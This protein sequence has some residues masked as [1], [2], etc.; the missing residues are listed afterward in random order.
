MPKN[1]KLVALLALPLLAMGLGGLASPSSAQAVPVA[2]QVTVTPPPIGPR[3]AASE[4]EPALAIPNAAAG[5]SFRSGVA[6]KG[7]MAPP[8]TKLQPPGEQKASTRSLTSCVGSGDGAC[9]R[10]AGVIQTL[11]N[12]TPGLT[13]DGITWNQLIKDP[14]VCYPGV[15]GCQQSPDGGGF[16]LG[17][18][19]AYNHG[20]SGDNNAVELGVQ[21]YTN[22]GGSGVAVIRPFT[23]AWIDGDPQCYNGCGYL[24]NAA[25]PFNVGDPIPA[26]DYNTAQGFT[27]ERNI[28]ANPA[29]WYISYKG[30]Y[31]GYW[32]DA[33]FTSPKTTAM[34]GACD[35][36]VICVPQTFTTLALA[37]VYGEV[38]SGYAENCDDMG[39]GVLPVSSTSA[40]LSSITWIKS[41]GNFTYDAQSFFHTIPTAWDLQYFISSGSTTYNGLRYGGPGHNSLGE[42]PTMHPGATGACGGLVEG[43][44]AASELQVWKESC[45]DSDAVKGCDSAWH[46]PWSG[47]VI[48]AC[49]AV[50]SPND[51][52][53][54]V[55][56]NALSSGKAFYVYATGACGSTRTLV[57]NASKLVTAWDIHGWAR[58]S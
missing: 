51:T 40:R 45:P 49:H 52:W 29:G 53:R 18:V 5:K 42:D 24:D 56:N 58:A 15:N 22:F 57:T 21:K 17:E 19:F 33:V 44:P 12:T 39:D 43:T 48:N 25:N 54:R 47:A 9:H 3:Q 37:Q 36:P 20:V 13:A 2:A 1:R 50:S 4:K 14:Y 11:G 38:A 34:G 41:T 23:F 10:W 30:S 55:W 31:L 26:A 8:G 7:V 27:I 6:P 16:S 32:P 35:N 46:V 28:P